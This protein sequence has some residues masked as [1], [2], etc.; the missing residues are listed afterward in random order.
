MFRE[1][2]VGERV[3]EFFFA[4]IAGIAILFDADFFVNLG[5]P[6]FR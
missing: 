3:V 6:P 4:A 5:P 1:E 2:A